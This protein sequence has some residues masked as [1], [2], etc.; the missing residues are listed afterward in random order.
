[1]RILE[2]LSKTSIDLLLREP[3][4]AHLLG[5]INKEVVS[6][7]HPVDTLA[8][9]LG[10][11]SLTLYVNADFWDHEL[12][13][14]L[15]RRGVLK[16]EMLHLVFR[17]LLVD[18]PMLDPQLLNIAFDLVV[19]QYID[20][21]QLPADSIFLDS[22]PDLSLPGGQ[23][24]YF[25]YKKLEDVKQ[26]SGGEF[27]G[28]PSAEMLQ[29]IKSDSHGMERHQPWREIRSRS[30]V[31]KSVLEVHQDSLLRTAHQRTSA[32]AWGSMP[33]EVREMLDALYQRPPSELNWRLLLKLFAA[34][35]ARTRLQNTIRRPSKRY[36]T[37]PGIKIRRQHR[38]LVAID[39]SGSIGKEELQLFFQEVYHIWRAG[40][41]VEIVECDTKIYRR[42]PYR[43]VTPELVQGRG[44]TS[45][46]EPLELADKERPDGMIY[47]T[48][49]YADTP[50][51]RVK[52]PILWLITPKGLEPTSAAWQAL[53]GRKLKMNKAALKSA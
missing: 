6:K 12:T 21:Q 29:K 22:F 11:N 36:G 45:F 42:Y 51:V 9:G 20:R 43:G 49:G 27:A 14:P 44:G 46:K 50:P 2:E 41:V 47:F 33:G 3:F 24:W 5:S 30:D 31:E 34:S 53:P 7:G 25:Y 35:A 15:F 16:H 32:S 8:V 18:E 39:T 26:G 13:D 23:T 37:S 1:M 28:T 52:I 48:D 10:R 38:L 19:N 4:Y 40:A 17:H